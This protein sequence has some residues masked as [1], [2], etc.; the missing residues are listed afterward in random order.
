MP[1]TAIAVNAIVF[2]HFGLIVYTWV[3]V[4]GILRPQSQTIYVLDATTGTKTTQTLPHAELQS[5]GST[6]LSF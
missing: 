3:E 2:P 6:S 4:R 1:R 5:G